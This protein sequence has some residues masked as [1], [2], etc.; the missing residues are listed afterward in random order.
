M[1]MKPPQRGAKNGTYDSLLGPTG[2]PE[3]ALG[4]WRLDE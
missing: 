2:Q 4:F 3:V 1:T